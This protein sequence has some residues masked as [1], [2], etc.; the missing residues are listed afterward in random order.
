MGNILLC[1]NDKKSADIITHFLKNAG[2][3][4]YLAT[5]GRMALKFLEN[6]EMDMVITEMEL[7]EYSGMEILEQ[8]RRESEIPVIFVTFRDSEL[9][10]VRALNQGAD[11]YMVKPFSYPELV[12]RVNSQLRRYE[13]L[14]QMGKKM[15][16]V[17]QVDEL[18]IDDER[19]EVT[20]G[21][22]EARLTHIEYQILLLLVKQHGRVFSIDQIYE[23]IWNM[24]AIGADN[25]IAV[26][27]RHIREK[28]ENNPKE[29]KYLKVVW[30]TGYKVG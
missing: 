11:D 2:H 23:S 19:R 24:K 4:V 29:P 6:M 12:A 18:V 1:E 3:C 25:T 14:V 15:K 26:H 5:D 21:G 27:I 17:Y 10:I 28:I 16:F 7:P 9:D 8:I 20:V 22:R 13:I 30:G